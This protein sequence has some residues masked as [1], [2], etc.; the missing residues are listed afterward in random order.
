MGAVDFN[1]A[2][3]T[4]IV[5]GG[6]SGIGYAIARAFA[7]ERCRVVIAAR[8]AEPLERAAA[9]LAADTGAQI[10]GVPTDTTD[11]RSVDRMVERACA[12]FGRLDVLVNC[13]AAPAGLVRNG[14]E[15]LD[16]AA[17]LADLN[18]KVVGYAR[19]CRAAVPVMKRQ[20]SG[21]I[22]QIGGLT[23]RSSHTLSGMRNVAIAHLTKTLSDQL[24]PFGITVNTVNPG[25]VRTPHLDELFSAEAAKR[26]TSAQEVEAGFVADTPI[27]RLLEP[28]EIARAVLFLASPQ[29]GAITGESVAVDG[30]ITRGIY[31]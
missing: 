5:T 17:L 19:C 23:G 21:R 31:L 8:R 26:G 12:A 20:Q 30:G 3:R 15:E 6:S 24:G 28:A 18:T 2:D 1:L 7:A 11:Q 16:A 13:A 22:V 29:A 4:V 25:V 10:I 9:A 27:R 14:I